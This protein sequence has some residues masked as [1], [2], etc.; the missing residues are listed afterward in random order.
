MFNLFKSH[1]MKL[2]RDFAM[3][4]ACLMVGKGMAALLPFAF[5]GSILGLFVLFFLLSTQ[6]I[7]LSWVH[8]GGQ[9]LLRHMRLLFIPVAAGLLG[10]ADVLSDG[11]GLMVSTAISG[12]VLIL[13]V[14]GRLYQRMLS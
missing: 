9:L 14:V 5:P 10:Y 3:L 7:P 1:H 2:I 6:L 4:L 12:L 8:D 11:L 13:L